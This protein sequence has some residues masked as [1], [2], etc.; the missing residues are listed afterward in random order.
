MTFRDLSRPNP[1]WPPS[2]TDQFS[3]LGAAPVGG[4]PASIPT[5]SLSLFSKPA[6]YVYSLRTTAQTA[7]EK[8]RLSN[9]IL[10]A[11]S[12][13]GFEFFAN[14]PVSRSRSSCFKGLRNAS[15]G[16]V[17]LQKNMTET[18]KIGA[19]LQRYKAL[20]QCT[21]LLLGKNSIT[22]SLSKVMQKGYL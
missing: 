10:N 21:G 11:T 14:A 4:E 17:T 20:L 7:F 15:E 5:P 6:S 3:L 19:P 13:H 9:H 12:K 16:A 18:S 2:T 22:S 1:P 8:P